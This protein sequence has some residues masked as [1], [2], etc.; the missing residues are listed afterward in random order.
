[1]KIVIETLEGK[2]E[3]DTE[4]LLGVVFPLGD[5]KSLTVAV[6]DNHLEVYSVGHV[7]SVEPRATNMIYVREAR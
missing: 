6:K 4:N 2:K 3:I 1:M 5:N 7:I